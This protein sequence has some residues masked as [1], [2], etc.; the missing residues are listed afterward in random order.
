VAVSELSGSCVAWPD[1]LAVYA[2]KATTDPDNPQDVATMDDHKKA[3]LKE[4][5]WAMNA[6]SSRTGTGTTTQAVEMD[7]GAGNIVETTE[8]VTKTTLY[9]TVTHKT[10]DEMA[11]AYNLTADQRAQLAQLLAEENHSTWSSVLNGL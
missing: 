7:D 3:L 11:D 4:I 2:V 9:I 10:A 8:T 6:V 1:M 5:F